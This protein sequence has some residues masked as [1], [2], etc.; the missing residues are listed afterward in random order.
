MNSLTWENGCSV[1][2]HGWGVTFTRR[3]ITGHALKV[4]LNWLF[5]GWYVWGMKNQG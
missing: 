5:A 1:A 3:V 2:L 4:G